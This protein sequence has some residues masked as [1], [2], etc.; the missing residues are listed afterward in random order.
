LSLHI[1]RH[2]YVKRS[3]T[4][5]VAQ[6]EGKIKKVNG[7]ITALDRFIQS[8]HIDKNKLHSKIPELESQSASTEIDEF[9]AFINSVS[10]DF[11]VKK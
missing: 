11:I 10:R 2:H 5:K 9:I 6:Y 3:D 1:R 4:G 7:R 8:L